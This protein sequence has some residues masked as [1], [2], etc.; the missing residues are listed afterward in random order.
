MTITFNYKT[1]ERPDP[2]PSESA[3]AIPITLI[4]SKD[5]I[6]IIGL[7]DSGADYSVIPK[8]MAEILGLDLSSKS[9]EI[10]GIGGNVKAIKTK[11]KINISKGRENYTFLIG[12]YAVED[13]MKDDFPILIGREDFFDKFKITFIESKKKIYIKRDLGN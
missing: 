8:D 7:L 1:I 13:D 11:M 6:D 2:F 9:E 4:G 3:P 12:V 10:G 5:K